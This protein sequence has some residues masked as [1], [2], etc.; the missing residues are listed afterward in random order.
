MRDRCPHRF[1]PLSLGKV[2]PKGLA[3]PYHGLVFDG[4]GACVHNPFGPA[5]SAAKAETFV[6]CERDDSVWLWH[7]D[8]SLADEA[9]IPVFPDFQIEE[10]FGATYTRVTLEGQ[11]MIGVENLLDL[12]HSSYLHVPTIGHW[13]TFDFAD[14]VF[15]SGWEGETIVARWTFNGPDGKELFWIQSTWEA[16]GTMTLSSSTDPAGRHRDPP[17][18]QLHLYTPETE[19]TTHYFTADR[20]ELGVEN[21]EEAKARHELLAS[22]VFAEDNAV[23]AAIQRELGDD[24]FFDLSPV[25]LS[26]DKAAVLARRHFNKLLEAQPKSS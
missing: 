14:S 5:P 26:I 25:L 3:C 7:G 24:D 15:I 9:S 16:P 8:A 11:L 2:T 10:G 6:V 21:L 20:H 19:T 18:T 23:V 17:Y 1:A 22:Q 13:E 12:T 4:T